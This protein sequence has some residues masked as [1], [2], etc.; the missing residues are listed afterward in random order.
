MLQWQ[1]SFHGD[2]NIFGFINRQA[3]LVSAASRGGLV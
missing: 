3:V 2:I 1:W